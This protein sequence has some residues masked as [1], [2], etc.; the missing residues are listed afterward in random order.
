MCTHCLFILDGSNF[1]VCS[2]VVVVICLICV[3]GEE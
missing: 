1:G 3:K 2:M